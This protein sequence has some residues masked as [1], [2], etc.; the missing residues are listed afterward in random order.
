[1]LV[2]CFKST[3]TNGILIESVVRDAKQER[4]LHNNQFKFKNLN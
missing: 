1:M 3:K 4:I 2:Q